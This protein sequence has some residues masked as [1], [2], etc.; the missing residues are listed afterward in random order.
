MSCCILWTKTNHKVPIRKVCLTY[1]GPVKV[2]IVEIAKKR[3]K[4]ED[5]RTGIEARII[6][7]AFIWARQSIALYLLDKN[8]AKSTN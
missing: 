1:S 6:L 5:L 2:K 7:N 3:Q 4:I 8:K